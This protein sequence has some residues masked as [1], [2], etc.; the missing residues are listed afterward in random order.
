MLEHLLKRSFSHNDAPTQSDSSCGAGSEPRR[1]A[2]ER[3]SLYEPRADVTHAN[4]MERLMKEKMAEKMAELSLSE[5][6]D[7][8]EPD[9]VYT[10]EIGPRKPASISSAGSGRSSS[11]H[12]HHTT[13]TTSSSVVTS[14]AHS[15][16]PPHRCHTPLHI[17]KHSKLDDESS[18]S[19]EDYEYTDPNE[20]L[21][22]KKKSFFRRQTERLM[23]AFRRRKEHPP[24]FETE[25]QDMTSPHKC[26]KKKKSKPTAS[27]RGN[28]SPT[29]CHESHRQDWLHQEIL[30]TETS[31]PD[32]VTHYTD[33]E[34]FHEESIRRKCA[35]PSL[36]K[37]SV[38]SRDEHVSDGGGGA[39][40]R[41]R[42]V[43]GSFIRSIKKRSSFRAKRKTPA[44]KGLLLL[45]VLICGHFF[46][47]MPQNR[48]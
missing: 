15:P 21:R 5:S 48:L 37:R 24:D 2:H 23:H 9:Y 1:H 11:V 28:K 25:S 3:G 7:N 12:V 34:Q 44:T 8:D 40:G 26:K 20:F 4:I 17:S 38:A 39:G 19:T 18:T 45:H 36:W 14:A 47:I 22:R 41:E 29:V 13:T 46:R 33:I 43:L 32:H 42:S 10:H 27:S 6:H 30:R 31:S 16:K 35:S